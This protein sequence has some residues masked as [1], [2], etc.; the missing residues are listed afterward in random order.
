MARILAE[1]LDACMRDPVRQPA[2]RI[3]VY[4]LRSTAGEV[5]P[6]RMNEVVLALQGLALLPA[7]VG[8]RALE[9]EVI[10]AQLTEVAG[11]YLDGGPAA[12]V[13][14]LAIS[15]A[16]GAL[17]PLENPPTAADP[18]AEGRW[19]RQGN[20]V[21]LREGDARVDPLLWPITFTGRLQGQVGASGGRAL[22]TATLSARAASREVDFLRQLS[23]SSD[24]P[25][26][27]AF[28]DIAQDLAES[29]LG[30]DRD[31]VALPSFGVRTTAFRSTQFVDESPLASLAKLLFPDGFLPRFLGDG[32][33][34][35]SSSSI[36]KAP[37]RN[38]EDRAP[39]LSIERPLLDQSAYTEVEL[40]GLDPNQT[41]VLQGRQTLATASITTGFFSRGAKIP[42]AWSDDGTQQA[43]DVRMEVDS[44]VADGA[45]NFG[46]ERFQTGPLDA[47][48]GCTRGVIE[49]DGAMELS[50]LIAAY[51][52]AAWISAHFKPDFV[53]VA[54]I[55]ASTGWTQPVGRLIEGVVGQALMSMLAKVGRGQYRI[56]GR[57]Y[58]WVFA[59]L[60]RTAQVEGLSGDEERRT[61]R[62]ENHL[63]NT[64][65][66]C[67]AIAVRVLRR[68]R[69]Q[70]NARQIRMLHDLA[71][72][73]DDLFGVGLGAARRTYVVTAIRRTLSRKG[74][75][76]AQ[77]EA[78]EVTSGV[79]P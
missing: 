20:A 59:E 21:V 10:S 25:Q 28:R 68:L 12:S 6:T 17:D 34:S 44:S 15:D 9:G 71:L 66:D 40:V 11:D 31:E 49:V 67:V 53:L 52:S 32:R 39:I 37:V 74:D 19:L 69:A 16:A 2:Y 77:V 7:V 4:D 41:A 13:L 36:A 46:G 48:G 78:F 3:D 30:L 54:G 45:F 27:T 50:I 70:Q 38:Y 18:Y 58:E 75:G 72:E 26:G 65:A 47:D 1:A 42:V 73:P 33:L 56:T 64:A 76:L 14:E 60:P 51:L 57:P 43:R 62:I 61:L 29:D 55:G 24:F 63:V 22:G 35:A 8:P 5:A 79:R 23:T